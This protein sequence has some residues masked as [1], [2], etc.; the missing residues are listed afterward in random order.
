VQRLIDL[1]NDEAMKFYIGG[2]CLTWHHKHLNY[3]AP[4]LVFGGASKP[5][6]FDPY[7]PPYFYLQYFFR[8]R[9][10]NLNLTTEEFEARLQRRLFDAD[11]PAD[12]GKHY[13]NL[14]RLV[15]RRY[16]DKK[17]KFSAEEFTALRVFIDSTRQRTWTP[18]MTDTVRHMD[19]ALARL[20]KL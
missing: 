10:W 7:T 14:S 6:N 13:A 1:V 12:A 17:A 5:V 8:E 3:L 9:C 4:D 19:E 20:E 15:L 16:D 18:R 11:A 2:G